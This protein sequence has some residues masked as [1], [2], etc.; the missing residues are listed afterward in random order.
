MILMFK[1]TYIIIAIKDIGG[2]VMNHKGTKIIET[3]DLVLRKFV[4][5]DAQAMYNNWAIIRM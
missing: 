2:N 3:K 5:E 1:K 4:L